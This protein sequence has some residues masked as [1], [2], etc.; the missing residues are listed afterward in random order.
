MPFFSLPP[1]SSNLSS[2]FDLFT[3]N[4]FNGTPTRTAPSTLFSLFLLEQMN[5]D[6]EEATFWDLASQSQN[7]A[8]SATALNSIETGKANDSSAT[9]SNNTQEEPGNEA[10]KPSVVKRI[11]AKRQQIEQEVAS[12]KATSPLSNQEAY[13]SSD[14]SITPPHLTADLSFAQL[15][16]QQQIWFQQWLTSPALQKIQGME[17]IK[18]L[19]VA[20]TGTS[21]KEGT[22]HTAKAQAKSSLTPNERTAFIQALQEQAELAY[23]TGKPFRVNIDEGTSLI[24]SLRNGEVNA[25]FILQNGNTSTTAID[26]LNQQLAQLQLAMQA[27]ELPVKHLYAEAQQHPSPQDDETPPKQPSHHSSNKQ[28]QNQSH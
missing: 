27:R 4:S 19:G 28:H 14:S 3:S 22:P 5:Q 15:S 23:K 6:V 16:P 24:L 25:K 11:E 13:S 10:L 2:G 7:D 17:G 21:T 26:Q 12:L 8:T 9:T 1:S 18:P 20:N